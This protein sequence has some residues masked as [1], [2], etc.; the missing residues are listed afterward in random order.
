LG[1]DGERFLQFGRIES[2]L[3]ACGAVHDNLGVSH[4]DVDFEHL[5]GKLTETPGEPPM[6]AIA[7]GS[8]RL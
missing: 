6:S 7:D 2:L 4:G 5:R 8:W 3:T 1:C